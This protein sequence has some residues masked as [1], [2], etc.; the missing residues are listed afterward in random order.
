MKRIIYEDL[1][2]NREQKMK[3]LKNEFNKLIRKLITMKKIIKCMK[4]PVGKT[5]TKQNGYH[6]K[7][8]SIDIFRVRSINNTGINFQ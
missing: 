2:S 8:I 6:R 5:L 7:K 3:E 4:N 1:M